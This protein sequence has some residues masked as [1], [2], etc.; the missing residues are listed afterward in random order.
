MGMPGV[1]VRW[2]GGDILLK[3]CEEKEWDV[4]RWEDRLKVGKDWTVKK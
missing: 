4:E 1:G 2:V 3:S